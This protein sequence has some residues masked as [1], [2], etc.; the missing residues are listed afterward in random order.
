MDGI[1]SRQYLHVLNDKK[2][3][4]TVVGVASD[5]TIKFGTSICSPTDSYDKQK[6]IDVAMEKILNKPVK[7]IHCKLDAE[8]NKKFIESQF[9]STAEVV[10]QQINN[11]YG[12]KK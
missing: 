4:I 1:I 10:K 12:K 5:N 11:N 8:H 6:G 7:I 3:V 2:R 9:D